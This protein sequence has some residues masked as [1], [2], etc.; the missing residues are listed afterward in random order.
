M[1]KGRGQ[2]PGCTQ[3]AAPASCHAVER[4][5]AR[6]RAAAAPPGNTAAGNAQAV[7]CCRGV[8]D[9]CS[10][11]RSVDCKGKAA[12]AAAIGGAPVPHSGWPA[13][14]GPRLTLG[15]GHRQ[16]TVDAG[17]RAPGPLVQAARRRLKAGRAESEHGRERRGA[18][19]GGA[20]WSGCGGPSTQHRSTRQ[21][22]GFAWSAGGGARAEDAWVPEAGAADS[23]PCTHSAC[24]WP[25]LRQIKPHRQAETRPAV[26]GHDGAGRARMHAPCWAGKMADEALAT[27]RE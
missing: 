12:A 10:G 25:R 24:F 4:R 17:E 7:Q 1:S 23:L 21:C 8:A 18:R 2:G 5:A 20:I 11:E 13:A 19:Q 22:F 14:Q 26:K 15:P 3:P 9:F 6:A 27:L 16:G